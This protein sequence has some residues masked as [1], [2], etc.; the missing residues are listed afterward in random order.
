M[1]PLCKRRSDA[2]KS[3]FSAGRGTDFGKRVKPAVTSCGSARFAWTAM[4]THYWCAWKRLGPAYATK[5]SGAAF[6]APSSAGAKQESWSS[7]RLHLNKFTDRRNGNE[8]AEARN[9]EGQPA[10][11]DARTFCTRGLENYTEFAKLR[12]HDRRS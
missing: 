3:C 8:Q 12:T 4:R 9:T 5:V 1:K 11:S 7:E 2:A 10:G 6:F